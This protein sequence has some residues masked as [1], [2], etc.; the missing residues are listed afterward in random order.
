MGL[1]DPNDVSFIQ[2]AIQFDTH[3]VM[4]KDKHFLNIEGI[5]RWEPGEAGRVLTEMNRGAAGGVIAAPIWNEYMRRATEGTEI[6]Y[7][8]GVEIPTSGKPILDGN[9]A[10]EQKVKIDKYSGKLATELTPESYIEEKV[11]REAHSILHYLY[12]DNPKGE[13]PEDPTTADPAYLYWETAVEK[14]LE[15]NS[16]TEEGAEIVLKSPPTE[17]D[18]VHIEENKPTV[19]ITSP[20]NKQSI[21]SGIITANVNATAP[22][23]IGRVEYYLDDKL[24]QTRYNYPFELDTTVSSYFGKGY[25]T[26]KVIA[27][28]DIDNSNEAT[29]EVNVTKTTSSP[30]I[31]WLSPSN[32]S[33]LTQSSFPRT[34]NVRLTDRVATKKI[35]FIQKYQETGDEAK[36]LSVVLPQSD[37]IEVEWPEIME[38]GKYQLFAEIN[39]YNGQKYRTNSVEVTIR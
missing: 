19:F 25:H 27:Y 31:K 30:N 7:F 12:K 37:I 4:S 2:I 9:I 14:W 29:V 36:V 1:K 32:N 24:I 5:K 21:S 18:D 23:G 38:K 34:F 39:G 10:P 17:Y 22:R 33:S 8:P 35:D 20:K 28:D 15:A 16:E 11:F 3:G 26:L 6:E 13:A